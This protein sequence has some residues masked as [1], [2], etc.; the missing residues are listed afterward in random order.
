MS[1]FTTRQKEELQ[2]SALSVELDIDSI[3]EWIAKHCL[4]EDVFSDKQLDDW[5]RAHDFIT[6]EESDEAVARAESGEG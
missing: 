2:S 3:L 4:P 6:Q 1:A 5:A